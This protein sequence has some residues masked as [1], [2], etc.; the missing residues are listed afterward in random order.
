[1]KRFALTLC[2][3]LLAGCTPIEPSMTPVEPPCDVQMDSD[4][5]PANDDLAGRYHLRKR[6]KR[7]FGRVA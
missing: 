2:L 6:T 3:F 1:M 7:F 4:C 5:C